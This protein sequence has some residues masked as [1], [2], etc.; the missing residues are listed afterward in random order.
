MWYLQFCFILK[1]GNKA[2]KEQLKLREI[3]LLQQKDVK[4]K[5]YEQSVEE[6]EAY[7]EE[8][9]QMWEKKKQLE[10]QMRKD[11]NDQMK[12][13]KDIIVR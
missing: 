2:L 5:T 11:L 6:Y 7:I 8:E 1:E 9:K 13:R 4:R 3:H 12:S 10:C